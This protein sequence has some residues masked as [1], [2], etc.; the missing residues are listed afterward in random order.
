MYDVKY[1]MSVIYNKYILNLVFIKLNHNLLIYYYTI[2]LKTKLKV[3]QTKS[4]ILKS[5]FL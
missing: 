4:Y 3:T 1:D 2:F 5:N